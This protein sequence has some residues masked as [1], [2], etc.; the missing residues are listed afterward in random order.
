MTAMRHLLWVLLKLRLYQLFF[1][2]RNRLARRYLYGAGLEIGA[3]HLPLQ[4]SRQATVKYVDHAP[5]DRLRT[6]YPELGIFRLTPVD[7][8]DDGETLDTVPLSSQEFIIANHFIEH[9]ENPIKTIM[10]HLSRLKPGGILYLA[11]P[12]RDKTFDKRRPVTSLDHAIKDYQDGPE[13]SR[14]EH[15]REWA[16]LVEKVPEEKAV[17]RA[18]E[19][20]RIHYSIHYHVWRQTDFQDMLSYMMRTGLK[21]GFI[22]QETASCRNEFIFILRK[23]Q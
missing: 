23:E 12:D 2:T 3:L 15:Y 9:C 20:I 8:I 21:P 22:I 17:D 10:T 19:L 18:R 14:F 13:W 4:V 6:I 1:P 11:V 16:R 5:V 7:I